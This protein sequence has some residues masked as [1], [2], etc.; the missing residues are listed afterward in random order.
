MHFRGNALSLFLHK[1]VLSSDKMFEDQE[2]MRSYNIYYDLMKRKPNTDMTPAYDLKAIHFAMTGIKDASV[3]DI[4]LY[5]DY[6][7]LV[8]TVVIF[9]IVLVFSKLLLSLC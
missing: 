7:T 4:M 3:E 9:I 8:R 6:D 5:N 1:L 2:N